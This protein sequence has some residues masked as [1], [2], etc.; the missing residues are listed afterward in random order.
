MLKLALFMKCLSK[1][2]VWLSM[3]HV[4]SLLGGQ[5]R[6]LQYF[7]YEK[8]RKLCFCSKCWYVLLKL[9]L[10][11][12]TTNCFF[13]HMR[14]IIMNLCNE[15]CLSGRLAWQKNLKLD[16]TCKLCNQMFSCL[17]CSYALL[18]SVILYH[19]HWS[20]LCLGV[21]RSAQSKTY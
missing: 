3:D 8:N 13:V 5:K 18:T 14:I 20:W 16:I 1:S 4:N 9:L 21:T 11:G 6:C 17:S 10:L 15:P 7:K 19:V 12:T 2:A